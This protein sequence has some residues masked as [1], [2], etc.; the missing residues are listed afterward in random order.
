MLAG[1]AAW[2]VCMGRVDRQAWRR[3][4]V[5]GELNDVMAWERGRS[6]HTPS[7]LGLT[8][9]RPDI[10][11]LFFPFRQLAGNEKFGEK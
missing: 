10:F 8:F 6:K 2:A 7:L 9:F 1:L 11:F 5:C 4:A 3:G